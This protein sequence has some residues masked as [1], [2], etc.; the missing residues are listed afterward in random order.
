MQPKASLFS[1]LVLTLAALTTF[2]PLSV[3][4]Y[5]PALPTIASDFRVDPSQVQLSLSTF[6]VGY[7]VG[8]LVYGPLSDRFGRRV[9]LGIGVIVYMI[10]SAGCAVAW[11]IDLLIVM[12][13]LQALGACAGTVLARAMIRDL[14]GK[15]ETARLM[16]M[17]IL[18][19][20]LAPMFAPII[21]GQV[22]TY[23]G[24]RAVFWVL[25]GFGAICLALVFFALRES[26]PREARTRYGV[27]A[28]AASYF[29][30]L[31]NPRFVGYILCGGFVF[32][33]MFAYISGSPFVFIEV[34]GVPPDYY[35]LLFAFHVTG[36]MIGATINSRLLPRYGADRMLTVGTVVAAS[37]GCVVIVVGSTG[38]G[39]IVALIITSWMFMSSVT[40]V[41]ANAAAGG[42]SEFPKLAGTASAL[43]GAAQFGIGS[44]TGYIVGKLHPDPTVSMALAIGCSGLAAFLTRLALLR[45]R[46][47]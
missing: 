17:M 22:L 19:T 38:L 23:A 45:P 6:L 31:Q 14:F 1:R 12:R 20:G 16:S 3:D 15:D 47:E 10:T 41:G 13:A 25:T 5:L 32:S 35:G 11:S 30:L 46:P 39:G 27:T 34:F 29:T 2:A 26:L 24:W 42:M 36:L 7:A 28:M 8:Q 40:M 44:L 4:M 37:M 21:G 33:G 9:P 43:L 18:V